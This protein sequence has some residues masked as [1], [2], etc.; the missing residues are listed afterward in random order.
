MISRPTY[1]DAN[2]IL[3]LF[4][5]RRDERMREARQWYTATFK[6]KRWDEL[7]TLMPPG[8]AE[9]TSFRMVVSYWDMVASFVVT[10][11]LNKELFFQSGRELLVVYERLKPVLPGIREAHKDPLYLGNLERVGLDFAGY[12]QSLNPEAYDAFVQRIG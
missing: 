1:D 9:N 6:P 3:R 2:L 11:V 10:G 12:W 4:E 5:M 7:A 8:S